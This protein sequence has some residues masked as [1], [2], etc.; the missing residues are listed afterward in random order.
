MN[1]PEGGNSGT[2]GTL[3]TRL[4]AGTTTCRTRMMYL[5]MLDRVSA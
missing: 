1:A 5:T 4:I 2:T 3:G